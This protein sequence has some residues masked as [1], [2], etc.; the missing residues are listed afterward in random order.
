MQGENKERWERLC[1]QAA[2]EQD[3]ERLLTLVQ[4]INQ[5]LAEKE[6]RLAHQRSAPVSQV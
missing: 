6:Q 2:V 3:S 1:A 5:L 4:E